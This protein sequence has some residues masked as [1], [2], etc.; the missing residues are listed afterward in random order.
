MQLVDF[1]VKLI[2]YSCE[3]RNKSNKTLLEYLKEEN[4]S[5]PKF[6]LSLYTINLSSKY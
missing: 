6:E 5:N 4:L 3:L 2:R 1:V